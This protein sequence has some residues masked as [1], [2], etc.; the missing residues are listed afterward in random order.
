MTT[1]NTGNPVGSADPRD[2][3]DNA[4]NMDNFIN[5]D[6]VQ[7]DDRLG[8]ARKS[9]A[10]M[11]KD[12]ADFL[13]NSGYTGTGTGGVIEDYAA[14]IEITAYNQLIRYDGNLYGAKASTDLPYTTDGTWAIDEPFLLNRDDGALRQDLAKQSGSGFGTDLV[15]HDGGTARQAINNR[16]ISVTSRAQMKAY[17][18]PEGYQFSLSD[19]QSTGTFRVYS[20]PS[21]VVDTYEGVYVTL[22]NGNHAKREFGQN[23]S[24]IPQVNAKWWPNS[25][26]AVSIQSAIDFVTLIGGG[27]VLY[28]ATTASWATGIVI[29]GAVNLEFTSDPEIT[30]DSSVSPAI[31]FRDPSGTVYRS[32]LSGKYRLIRSEIEWDDA[33]DTNSI[34]ILM[35]NCRYCEV[36]AAARYY[37]TGLLMLGKGDGC[38][39]NIVKI[40]HLDNCRLGLDLRDESVASVIGYTNS[41]YIY[42]GRIGYSTGIVTTA[43]S[44][45][46]AMRNITISF[47]DFQNN[48]NTIEAVSLES[49]T[50]TGSDPYSVGSVLLRIDG[51]RNRI[52]NCR[53]EIGNDVDPTYYVQFGAGSFGNVIDGGRIPLDFFRKINDDSTATDNYN[54]FVNFGKR[55]CRLSLTANE[56]IGTAFESVSWDQADYDIDGLW[57]AATPTLIIIPEHVRRIRVR[58]NLQY[59][60]A[61]P[62]ARALLRDSGG[63]VFEGGFYSR[64]NPYGFQCTS[65]EMDVTPGES[66]RLDTSCVSG[67]ATLQ[68]GSAPNT[69]LEV[70]VLN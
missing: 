19:G 25:D 41:N 38:V 37:N 58:C 66:I 17:D 21:P 7:Y 4:E 40:D 16:V 11:E 54:R 9:W 52:T 22:G 46:V 50:Q 36:D 56:T 55:G 2:L 63:G 1:Y 62:E 28:S 69:W 51:G 5:G 13:A 53:Y 23:V 18:V 15:G 27:T 12:F 20:G 26:D 6:E 32:K 35:E 3:Y 42:G 8:R 67:S 47:I 61:E 59:S 39:H 68:G 44:N 31:T 65:S 48:N 57:D 45:G 29:P 49:L 14:G 70:E 34:G 60:T 30:V 10:G 33:T 64:G 24:Y 43:N